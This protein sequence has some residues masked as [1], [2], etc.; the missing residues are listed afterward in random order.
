[1]FISVKH[2]EKPAGLIAGAEEQFVVLRPASLSLRLEE[3]RGFQLKVDT[4]VNFLT[5]DIGWL[6]RRKRGK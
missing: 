2:V 6:P 5:Q 4:T 3:V 1:M